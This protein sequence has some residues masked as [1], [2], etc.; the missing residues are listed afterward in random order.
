MKAVL[1][2]MSLFVTAIACQKPSDDT[3]PQPTEKNYIGKYKI[4][5]MFFK[6]TGKPDQDMIADQPACAQDDLLSF[7][8]NAIFRYIDAGV[9]CGDEPEA[10]TKWSVNGKKMT[11]DGVISDILSFDNKTLVLSTPMNMFGIQGVVEQ[12]LVKQ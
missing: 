7:E 9:S 11:I 1:L 2:V 12:T 8:A 4:A 10:P 5:K 6:V 3:V